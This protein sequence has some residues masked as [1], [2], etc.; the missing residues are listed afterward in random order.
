M[1][2]SLKRKALDLVLSFDTTGS[3]SSAIEDVRK[4]VVK[5]CE[6][7]SGMDLDLRVSVI[8]HGDYGDG[9][10]TY[11]VLP[12]SSD[13]ARVA[14]FVRTAKNTSGGDNDECYE[15]VLYKAGAMDWRP[16]ADKVLIMFGD[17]DPHDT[18][19]YR[20][21]RAWNRGAHDLDRLVPKD[22]IL[23]WRS[24]VTRLRERRVN[25]FGVQCLSSRGGFWDQ[26]GTRFLLRD[27]ASSSQ[28]I[29]ATVHAQTGGDEAVRSYAQVLE[30]SGKMTA[31][32][33]AAVT[34]L[35]N[36]GTVSKGGLKG[37]AAGEFVI[38][39]VPERV[40]IEDLIKRQGLVFE[41][42][43]LFYQWTKR[44]R[45]IQSGKQVVAQRKDKPDEFYTG[46]RARTL[47][48]L[49]TDGKTNAA[50][51]APPESSAYTFYIRSDSMNR[52]VLPGTR[53]LY[54]AKV[55]LGA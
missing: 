49:P 47:A 19:G 37:V 40:K 3:M 18:S 9:L 32:T 31:D 34:M 29:L 23:D 13:S 41:P 14:A 2:M 5:F 39:D 25:I 33:R 15:L 43:N 48:G 28:M 7:L 27:F 20:S 22:L 55:G 53:I 50:N 42:G 38:L 12:F 6:H 4:N 52:V 24:E 36:K 46:D 51:V 45:A 11:Q 21:R 26:I 44:E 30:R 35:L 16:D 10:N 54:K 1:I 17:A 8:A